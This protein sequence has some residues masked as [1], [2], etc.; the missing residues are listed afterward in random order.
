MVIKGKYKV[1]NRGW[2]V[3]ACL[4]LLF[5]VFAISALNGFEKKNDEIL[6]NENAVIPS[7]ET[8]DAELVKSD[9]A[10]SID[11]QDSDESSD[12]IE[13]DDNEK[14]EIITTTTD[15]VDVVIEEAEF[16]SI[17]D[18]VYFD[19]DQF[20]LKNEYNKSLDKIYDYVNDEAQYNIVI[21]GNI[22]AYPNIEITEEGQTISLK[23]A[24]AIQAYF[25]KK[26]IV[27]ERILII[28]NFEKKPLIK[29]GNFV[30]FK[31]NRRADIYLIKKEN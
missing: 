24:E 6:N 12:V 28:D 29:E 13:G 18:T 26:G 17:K 8:A 1:T 9:S 20:I 27:S 21:E 2:I 16:M 25:V 31:V 22:N 19:G 11:T 14:A 3:G 7:D 30:D 5:I 10:D 15:I 4:L 23:R